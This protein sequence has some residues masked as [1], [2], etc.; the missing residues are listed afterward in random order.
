MDLSA[1]E[2]RFGQRGVQFERLGEDLCVVRLHSE[3]GTVAIALNGA[4]VLE[5]C[6][7]DSKAVL[8]LSEKANLENG[9]PI[10]GGIPICWPWFG[11]H[12]DD[13][14]QPA[15][16]F[17]RISQWELVGILGEHCGGELGA[18]FRLTDSPS[19]LRMWPYSF[20]LRYRVRVLPGAL[21]LE[22]VTSNQGD[23][24]FRISEALHSYFGIQSIHSATVDGLDG[25]HYLDQ[26]AGMERKLQTGNIQFDREVDRIYLDAPS[27]ARING[28]LS[29][30][31]I[32]IESRGSGSAV[33]W[34]PW[35]DKAMRMPDFG[36][37][38]YLEM[39]CYETAN[40]GPHSI[41]V[42]PGQD[43]AIGASIRAL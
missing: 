19:S 17:A 41:A 29:G 3:H 38:E 16:G 26:L 34:N 8:W 14:E 12:P 37:D 23:R 15:H 25:V 32:E 28:S 6:G 31:Q 24:A 5:Y 35:I 21:D 4:H 11:P 2:S 42:D 1:L 10:R 33:V 9:K 43:H 36:D 40:A 18:E 27:K 30:K 22:L 39:L 13:S 7:A 20:E